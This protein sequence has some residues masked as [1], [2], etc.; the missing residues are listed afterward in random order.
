[1]YTRALDLEPTNRLARF[2]LAIHDFRAAPPYDRPAIIRAMHQFLLVQDQSLN[3]DLRRRQRRRRSLRHTYPVYRDGLWFRARYHLALCRLMLDD[4]WPRADGGDLEAAQRDVGELVCQLTHVQ[5][6][7]DRDEPIGGRRYSLVMTDF[8]AQF[9]PQL[10]VMAASI[11]LKGTEHAP[12]LTEALRAH[13]RCENVNAQV[14]IQHAEADPRLN[15]RARYNLACFYA[16]RIAD[17]DDQVDS[18]PTA[19]A[20]LE[21]SLDAS[22]EDLIDWAMVDP[23]LAPLRDD[24]ETGKKF[25][26]LVAGARGTG[27]TAAPADQRRGHTRAEATSPPVPSRPSSPKP[28]AERFVHAATRRLPIVWTTVPSSPGNHGP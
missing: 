15:Y 27:H 25:Q 12:Q 16:R 14:L 26:E 23:A 7:S 28:F 6:Q 13:L 10:L 9:R 20:E 8:A 21:L 17:G 19:L 11:L 18:A 2:D 4:Q 3:R 5:N 22:A 1:M 24:D